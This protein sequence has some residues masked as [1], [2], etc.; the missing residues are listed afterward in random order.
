MLCRSRR[1]HL[2]WQSQL[3][4]FFFVSLFILM[5]QGSVGHLQ[6]ICLREKSNSGLTCVFQFYKL[7]PTG[8][9]TQCT[10]WLMTPSFIILYFSEQLVVFHSFLGRWAF[11]H[12]AP[13]FQNALS[14]TC[15]SHSFL[16]PPSLLHLCQ[17]VKTQLRH[18]HTQ[19]VFLGSHCGTCWFASTHPPFFP[20][21]NT[22]ITFSIRGGWAS[23]WTQGLNL[24]WQANSNNSVSLTS[25]CF[26]NNQMVQF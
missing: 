13:F 11:A 25:N 22:L 3:V 16:G 9:Q 5:S 18:C 1:I 7:L 12:S 14:P 8:R 23:S 20:L 15:S 26:R 4:S 24:Y 21:S 2:K 19:D 6:N 10:C 17:H